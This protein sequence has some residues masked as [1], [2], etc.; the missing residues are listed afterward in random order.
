[1]K[2]LIIIALIAIVFSACSN[3]AEIPEMEKMVVKVLPDNAL[4]IKE[5]D[6]IYNVGDTVLLYKRNRNNSIYMDEYRVV[7]VRKGGVK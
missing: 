3:M 4:T 6:P 1:M 2:N 7:V 5:L